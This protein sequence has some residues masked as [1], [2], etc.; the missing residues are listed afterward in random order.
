MLWLLTHF[1]SFITKIMSKSYKCQHLSK[2]E[3]FLRTPLL[4]FSN[5]YIK[6][7]SFR[8]NKSFNIK[9]KIMKWDQGNI[10]LSMYCSSNSFSI[11]GL[12]FLFLFMFPFQLL[13]QFCFYLFRK[14]PNI[15]SSQWSQQLHWLISV[16][17]FCV[18]MTMQ[19]TVMLRMTE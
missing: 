3:G 16:L 17:F 6:Y 12:S 10:T 19:S 13:C 18:F 1:I 2:H 5:N 7:P 4:F 14:Y 9:L 11:F 15:I 8:I